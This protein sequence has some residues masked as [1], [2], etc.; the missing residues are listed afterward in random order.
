MGQTRKET[1]SFGPVEVPGRALLGRPDAAVA[2]EFPHRRGA[3]AAPLIRA[4]GLDQAGRGDG[5]TSRLGCWPPTSARRIEAAAAEVAEGQAR[6]P[7]P[8][9]GL[10]DRLGHPDQHERQRGHRQPRHR[11][12]RRHHR[13]EVAG[14]PQRPRQHGP[15]APTTPSRPHACRGGDRDRR[16]PAARRSSAARRARRQGDGVRRHHQDRP[17]PPPGR[18]AAHP[19]PGVLRLRRQ[20]ENGIK[21]VEPG[22]RELLS[23]AQGGTA[24][25]TGLNAPRLRRGDRRRASPS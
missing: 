15:V 9:R 12:A 23:L 7:V 10:A 13:L 14:A 1:D 2:R 8:A 20:V 3:H 25:G 5:S 6:R 11:A 24:V 4:L 18:D 17:H 19:R 16:A 21:R 22:A